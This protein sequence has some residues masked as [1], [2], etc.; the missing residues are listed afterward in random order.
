[1][2]PLQWQPPTTRALF[3]AAGYEPAYPFWVYEI[4]FISERY[5]TVSRRAIDEAGCIVRAFRKKRGDEEFKA[6]R[7][8]AE[9]DVPPRV[10]IPRHDA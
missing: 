8:T 6:W 1:M 4:D 3:E 10:G 9:R 5:G 7:P 2:F